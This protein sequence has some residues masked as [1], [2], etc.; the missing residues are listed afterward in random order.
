MKLSPRFRVNDWQKLAFADEDD[1]STAI[2]IVQDR[3]EGRFIKWIDRMISEEFAGFAIVALDCL[4]LETLY[5]FQFG[6][7]TDGPKVYKVILTAPP[8]E[9]SKSLAK[10]FYWNVRHGVIHDTETRKGWL[11]RMTPQKS[12]A[13]S[14]ASGNYILNRTMFHDGLKVVFAAWVTKL[15]SGDTIL[16][17][18][19]R[20]RMNEIIQ[21]HSP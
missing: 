11:I 5:G 21:R 15:R 7:T 4:F 10:S 16:R 13:E 17:Q 8:F 18:N 2:D 3:V 1:W 12:I 6:S 9:F 20:Q 19:M 14:D